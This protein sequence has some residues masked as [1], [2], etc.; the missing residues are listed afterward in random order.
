MLIVNDFNLTICLFKKSGYFFRL[1]IV[2][3][4]NRFENH[5]RNTI[6]YANSLYPDQGQRFVGLYLGPNCLTSL[7]ADTA[8]VGKEFSITMVVMR[9]GIMF[10]HLILMHVNK[11]GAGLSANPPEETV[12]PYLLTVRAAKTLIRLSGYAG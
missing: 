4:I 6:A 2:S 12:D 11:K 5:V 9:Y 10:Q 1:L 7:S 8:I 3:K